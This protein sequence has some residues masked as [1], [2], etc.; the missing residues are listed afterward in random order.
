MRVFI[1]YANKDRELAAKL[2]EQLSQAGFEVWN[3]AE[4][5]APGD[6][7]A[8]KIGE[9]LDGSDVMV[10]LVT[11]GSLESDSLRGDIQ[12]GLTSKKFEHRVVPV[13]VGYVTFNAGEDVPWIL[14]RM[15]P[16][17]IGSMSNAFAPEAF[18]AVIRRVQAIAGQETNVAR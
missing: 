12:Y 8:K 18:D 2:A 5:I 16:V 14:L 6:N 7:W 4:E 15:N 3:P 11:R 9:A 17:Y 10:V 13:L 1:S